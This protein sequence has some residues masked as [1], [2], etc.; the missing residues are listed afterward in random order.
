MQT[1][2][3]QNKSSMTL[4]ALWTL[5]QGQ[6]KAVRYGLAKRLNESIQAEKEAKS[7]MTESEFYAKIDR[8]IE[9]AKQGRVIAMKEDETPDQ[10]LDRLLCTK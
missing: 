9:S 2:T 1:I 8:S 5:I 3:V 4:D 10:F 6:S 7:K